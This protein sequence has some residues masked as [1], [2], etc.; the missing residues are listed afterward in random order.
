MSRE[1][2]IL[3]SSTAGS[4]VASSAYEDDLNSCKTLELLASVYCDRPDKCNKEGGGEMRLCDLQE[5]HFC[6]EK[7]YSRGSSCKVLGPSGTRYHSHNEGES[8]GE[9]C[10]DSQPCWHAVHHIQTKILAMGRRDESVVA[11]ISVKDF[12]ALSRYLC[13]PWF[14]TRRVATP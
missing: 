5:V 12:R 11:K 10:G 7:Y 2:R 6:Q 8:C 14:F 13:T 3:H 9:A 4:A 1:T